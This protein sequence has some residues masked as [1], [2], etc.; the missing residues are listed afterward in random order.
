MDR[1]ARYP[2]V[3]DVVKVGLTYRDWFRPS[4]RPPM[5]FR[6]RCVRQIPWG[7]D[8]W[9]AQVIEGPRSYL[10]MTVIV[11]AGHI[12]GLRTGGVPIT[13]AGCLVPPAD[14][15]DWFPRKP[16][17]DDRDTPYGGLQSP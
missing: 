10:G 13:S 1:Y 11:T 15:P 3:S 12:Y 7:Q 4:G 9:L 17:P 14:M 8:V 16:R 5:S 2:A 6:A